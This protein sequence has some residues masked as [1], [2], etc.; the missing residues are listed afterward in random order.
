MT[1]GKLQHL[2]LRGVVALAI[3]LVALSSPGRVHS[4]SE[5]RSIRPFKV[6]VPQAALDDLRRRIAAAWEQPEL[7]A[8]ELRAAFRPLRSPH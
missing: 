2:Y 3:A 7:L 4:A 5:D 6:Q 8:A 1:F